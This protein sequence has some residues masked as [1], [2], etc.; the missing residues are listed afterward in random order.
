MSHYWCLKFILSRSMEERDSYAE[1]I[2]ITVGKFKDEAKSNMDHMHSLLRLSGPPFQ[3]VPKS[4]DVAMADSSQV[5][6]V[7]GQVLSAIDVQD[8]AESSRRC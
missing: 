4:E 5:G 3:C 8:E 2:R 7:K 1:L 6:E